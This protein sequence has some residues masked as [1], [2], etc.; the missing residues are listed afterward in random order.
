MENALE[1][2][3]AQADSG[4]NERLL[5]T[6]LSV[7][8][9]PSALEWKHFHVISVL[10]FQQLTQAQCECSNCF[11]SVPF[12]FT[13]ACG[14]ILVGRLV[15]VSDLGYCDPEPLEGYFKTTVLCQRFFYLTLLITHTHTHTLMAQLPCSSP[16]P[17]GG[18]LRFCPRTH[19]H[20][21]GGDRKRTSV[22]RLEDRRSSK[23]SLWLV[24][25]L[26]TSWPHPLLKWQLFY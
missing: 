6:Q 4:S 5:P 2:C 14:K 20:V 17:P 8:H 22:E 19:Q 10:C 25:N 9:H 13:L 16:D 7:H 21:T 23:F 26:S 1:T 15:T 11:V 24:D 18:N 3:E 12:H